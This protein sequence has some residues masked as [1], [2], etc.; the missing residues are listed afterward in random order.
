MIWLRKQAEG[1]NSS[2]SCDKGI[3]Y[4]LITLFCD[5]SLYSRMKDRQGGAYEKEHDSCI[6]VSYRIGCDDCCG[7]L[8]RP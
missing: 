8:P 2:G 1:R 5:S 3:C 6:F 7:Q 4:Y